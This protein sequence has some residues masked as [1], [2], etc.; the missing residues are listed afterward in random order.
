LVLREV[1]GLRDKTDV[2]ETSGYTSKSM[3]KVTGPC[4]DHCVDKMSCD[5][6]TETAEENI[7]DEEKMLEQNS[8][9][10]PAEFKAFPC[11]KTECE[12]SSASLNSVD[13]VQMTTRA[14]SKINLK[15]N[16]AQTSVNKLETH[17]SKS[18]LS[19]S[20]NNSL[21]ESQIYSFG[22]VRNMK[23]LLP[24]LK[25]T[26]LSDNNDCNVKT[27]S[28][29]MEVSSTVRSGCERSQNLD[30]SV[31]CSDNSVTLSHEI[32]ASQVHDSEVELSGKSFQGQGVAMLK[33]QFVNSNKN[34]PENSM[35]KI[36]T[37]N[38]GRTLKPKPLCICIRTP[39]FGDDIVL[40][41]EEVVIGKKC[42]QNLNNQSHDVTS[43][44]EDVVQ[45]T[46]EEYETKSASDMLSGDVAVSDVD[47]GQQVEAQ[48]QN[49][50]LLCKDYDGEE[51]DDEE[52]FNEDII[53]THGKLNC[54]LLIITML[55]L[56]IAT[57]LALHPFRNMMRILYF[58]DMMLHCGVI[59]FN[60]PCIGIVSQKKGI[61]SCTGT[62]PQNV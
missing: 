2:E 11:D 33:K 51:E 6:T 53:C 34:I 46:M 21:N 20:C 43:K 22:N 41:A 54:K 47:N 62:V 40:S 57:V 17:S 38:S 13:A 29:E 1:E 7:S 15:T 5:S 55:L 4:I 3:E 56:K 35:L 37:E 42:G 48:K 32:S 16:N 19:L 44:S 8:Q 9:K 12:S 27:Q 58:C 50:N 45:E 18:S 14:R 49:Y 52:G 28:V 25:R 61:L 39:G 26:V 10:I 60:Y 30:T 59:A 31:V 23:A 24:G 36:S